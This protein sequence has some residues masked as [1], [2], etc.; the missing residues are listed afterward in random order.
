VPRI[1]PVIVSAWVIVG[2]IDGSS[3]TGAEAVSR[4]QWQKPVP[5]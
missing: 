1:I 2:D 4:G 5:I 3:E